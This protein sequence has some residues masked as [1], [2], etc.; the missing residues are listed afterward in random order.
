VKK[1]KLISDIEKFSFS[2]MTSNSN[3][4][5]S[6][7]GTMGVLICTIGSFCFLLGTFDKMF[8]GKD[9]DI[10]IQSI[11][12]VGIGA[13][14]LG[15]RKSKDAKEINLITTETQEETLCECPEGC[16]CGNC[17]RCQLK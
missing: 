4:K 15:Y 1:K 3:G 10:L 5:T 6:S 2:Q 14:L 17:D 13:A 7:S 16:S 11:I 8:F 9:V 12:F